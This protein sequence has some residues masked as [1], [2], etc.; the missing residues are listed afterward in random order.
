V[1]IDGNRLP[2]PTPFF[3]Y[4]GGKTKLR[5]QILCEL[6]GRW[7]S[8]VEEYR[9]P[10]F[11]GGSVGILFARGTPDVRRVWINDKD[12][13]IACLWTAVIRSPEA[14]I[15][16]VLSFTPSVESFYTIKQWLL[17]DPPVPKSPSAVTD[18]GFRKLAI[19]QI[20]YSGLG[21][22]SGGPL[23]G[24]F[25]ES[26]YPIDC[27][28]SPDSICGK[29]RSLHAMFSRLE[30]RHGCCTC[31]DFQEVID[32]GARRSLIYLDPPYYVK[33]NDLYQCKFYHDDH[34][35]L[36][37]ILRQTEHDWVLSYDDQTDIRQWYGW[38][39]VSVID[40]V[41]YSITARVSGGAPGRRL[42]RS[43]PELLI[44]PAPTQAGRETDAGMS[45][46]PRVG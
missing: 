10:F 16:R 17:T 38:A 40:G 7:S 45:G 1:D 22:Q 5:D 6:R 23:G 35:R 36:R 25:Q 30:V 34:L 29:I 18:Y 14:L 41:N 33:G 19:H 44:A 11:G 42:S 37:R 46:H 9:E 39:S 27:R 26:A 43:R 28:W 32:D 12:P 15:R 3:R 13:G 20:S 2:A 8:D 31:L 24:E 4:P 21:T